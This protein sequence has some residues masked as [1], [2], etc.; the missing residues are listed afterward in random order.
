MRSLLIVIQRRWRVA[1]WS[2]EDADKHQPR[3]RQCEYHV[4]KCDDEEREEV[5]AG[6]WSVEAT[7]T[8]VMF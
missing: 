2:D 1:P 5:D 7:I 6:V 4:R 8:A 3:S